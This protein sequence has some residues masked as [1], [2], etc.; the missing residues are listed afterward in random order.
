MCNVFININHSKNNYLFIWGNQNISY[1]NSEDKMRVRTQRSYS[2]WEENPGELKKGVK[3][4]NSLLLLQH[5]LVNGVWKAFDPVSELQA[6]ISAK[7]EIEN[8]LRPANDLLIIKK[9]KKK[10]F[11]YCGYLQNGF[12]IT[13]AV[14]PSTFTLEEFSSNNL[15]RTN[16]NVWIFFFS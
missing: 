11:F 13:S 5:F 16:L 9:K 4:G 3:T 6:T 14:S 8:M 10:L 2:G 12:K 7:Q 15:L 1:S